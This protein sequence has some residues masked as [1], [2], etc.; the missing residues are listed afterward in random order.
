MDASTSGVG[1]VQSQ[2]QGNTPWLHPCAFS[3]ILSSAEQNYDIGNRELLAIKLALEEWRYWLEGARH[4]FVVNTNHWNLE[5]LR[6]TKSQTSIH[7]SIS[8]CPGTKN[9]KADALS[10]L[11]APYDMSENPEPPLQSDSQSDTVVSGWW[12]HGCKCLWSYSAGVSKGPP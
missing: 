6:K 11:H 7:F 1:A 12:H 8:Y 9:T 2:Q 3:R 10:R 5:C 4:L